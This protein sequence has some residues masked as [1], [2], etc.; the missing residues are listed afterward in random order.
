M[1]QEELPL[2]PKVY[3]VNL[4]FAGEVANEVEVSRD[5]LSKAGEVDTN[6][7]YIINDIISHPLNLVIHN[8][9]MVYLTVWKT[10]LWTCMKG[11][12]IN[13]KRP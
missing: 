6:D 5:P 9:L 11:P 2:T 4:A 1:N 13:L 12:Y 7:I 3:H 8:M 10:C